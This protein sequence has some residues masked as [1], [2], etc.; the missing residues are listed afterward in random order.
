[1]KT[2]LTP[3]QIDDYR[4]DGCLILRE[5]LTENELET[6]TAAI[7]RCVEEMGA[8]KLSGE[9]GR[10]DR[11][12]QGNE[13]YDRV[14]IQRINLWKIDETVKSFFLDPAL[15]EM[16]CRL[17]G[18]DG[19]RI[20]HD[21]TLQ[22]Q[23]WANP[24]AWHSDDPKWSFHTPHAIS[25]WIALD[26]ATIQNGCMYYVP[27]SHKLGSYENL[28]IRE[29]TGAYFEVFP[30]FKGVQ[31]IVGEMKAGDAGIHNGLTAH[32]AGPN[33]TPGWRRAMT[34]AYMPAGAT[35]NGIPNILSEEQLANLE[36]G[37]V[38]DDE[39]QNPLVWSKE[40]VAP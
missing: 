37:D 36:V 6:L 33:M 15:G 24:T 40:M 29:D 7:T 12:K 34:C 25:I 5:F 35:F 18:I 22:K 8:W 21:Q 27:G 32:G 17:E 9:V 38:L 31:P 11:W 3:A 10:T 26:D 14:F 13:Y 23:P 30:Q 2:D 39:S 19:I 16:L 28:A 4:R 1:M 20:W